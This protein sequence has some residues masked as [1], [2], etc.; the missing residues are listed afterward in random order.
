LE[1]K[2]KPFWWLKNWRKEGSIPLRTGARKQG[3]QDAL[4]LQVVE[5]FLE[6]FLIVIEFTSSQR[7]SRITLKEIWLKKSTITV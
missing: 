3:Q 5:N 6:I 2:S 7:P 4:H 1:I